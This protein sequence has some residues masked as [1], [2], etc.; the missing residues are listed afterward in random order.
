MVWSIPL[1]L[2][3]FVVQFSF[4]GIMA[5]LKA[6]MDFPSFPTMNGAWFPSGF[7]K[8]EMGWHNW[9]ENSAFVHFMHRSLGT[10]LLLGASVVAWLGWKESLQSPFRKLFPLLAGIVWFQ[11]ILGVITVLGSRGGI[12]VLPGVLHQSGAIVLSIVLTILLFWS[13]QR[14]RSE[15]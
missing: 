2:L 4:G 3:G 15:A 14:E 5:G 6:A 1:L 12:P 7:W 10:L 8:V 13:C 11:F 9:F